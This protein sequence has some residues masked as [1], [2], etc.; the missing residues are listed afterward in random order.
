MLNYEEFK[1]MVEETFMENIPEDLRDMELKISEVDRINGRFDGLSV[2]N[3]NA[4]LSI[5]P[6]IY[7]N[8]MY[9]DYKISGNAGKVILREAERLAGAVRHMPFKAEEL[10]FDNAEKRIVFCLINREQNME[11]LKNMP[12]RDFQDLAVIY[13]MIVGEKDGAISSIMITDN[14]ARRIGFTEDALYN[15]AYRNTRE[16]MP[17]TVTGIKEA[18]KGMAASLDIA[19]SE[20]VWLME[21]MQDEIPLWVMS[22]EKGFNGASVM[23]YEDKLQELA[24][25]V[26]ADL[27]IIP[28]SIHEIIAMPA[29]ENVVPEEIAQ[30]VNMVNMEEVDLCERLSNNVYFYDKNLREISMATDTPNKRLDGSVAENVAYYETK[31]RKTQRF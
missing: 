9:E 8:D 22:N 21:E 30:V 13:R 16:I 29:T 5:S 18:I 17:P 7:I 28:S 3:G 4:G 19:E 11:L 23:L 25:H 12:H 26:G 1:K 24:Q 10:D 2:V 20:T 15:H 14:I 6:T 27:F 31:E